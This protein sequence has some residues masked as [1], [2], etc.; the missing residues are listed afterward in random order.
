M[1]TQLRIDDRLFHGEI[2]VLWVPSLKVNSVVVADDEYASNQ[3]NIVT[4]QLSKPKYVKLNILK[5]DPFGMILKSI[6]FL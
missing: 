1:I 2:I 5:I 3:L 6:S 4:A